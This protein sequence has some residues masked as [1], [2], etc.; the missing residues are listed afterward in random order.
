M[1]HPAVQV[2]ENYYRLFNDK[3][4]AGIATTFDLPA[5]LI[6][7]PRKTLLETPNAVE[8]AYRGLGAK[9]AQEGVARLSWDRG[10]FALLQVHDDFAV[11]KTVVTR[12]AVDRTPI[13]T[14]NCSYALRL[15]GKDWVFTLLTSDDSGNANAF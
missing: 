2:V 10:S 14:W 11:V 12:E 15:V 6:I 4:W 9:F 5:T 13:K 8:A 7:G 1:L 3:N